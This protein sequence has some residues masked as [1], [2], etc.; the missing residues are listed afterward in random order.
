MTVREAVMLL[1]DDGV[2][3]LSS[4]RTARSP[5]PAAIPVPADRDAAAYRRAALRALLRR[6]QEPT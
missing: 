5:T 2:T 3:R 6:V 1:R 4:E